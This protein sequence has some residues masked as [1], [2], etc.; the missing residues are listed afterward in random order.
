MCL[1]PF[2]MIKSFKNTHKIKYLTNDIEKSQIKHFD[3]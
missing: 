1:K 2:L 3:F